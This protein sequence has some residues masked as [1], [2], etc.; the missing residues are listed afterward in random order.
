MVEWYVVLIRLDNNM[1]DGCWRG[2]WKLAGGE[3]TGQLRTL[4]TDLFPF[5]SRALESLGFR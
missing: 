5:A 3:L 2:V 4:E 1:E